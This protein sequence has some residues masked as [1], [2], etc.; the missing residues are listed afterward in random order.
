MRDSKAINPLVIEL[1]II[2]IFERESAIRV[3]DNSRQTMVSLRRLANHAEVRCEGRAGGQ[4][5]EDIT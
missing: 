3:G 1:S 4:G 5:C 2:V